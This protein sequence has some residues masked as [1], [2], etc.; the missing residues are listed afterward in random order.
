MH[1]DE[2]CNPSGQLLPSK[3]S[4]NIGNENTSNYKSFSHQQRSLKSPSSILNVKT[5]LSNISNEMCTP[6]GQFRPS[7]SS[8]NVG[9]ENTS[10]YKSFSYQQRSLQS[11]SSIRNVRTPLSN[12]SNGIYNSYNNIQ[13]PISNSRHQSFF[14]NGMQSI[15]SST[16]IQPSSSDNLTRRN[17]RLKR[18]PTNISAIPMFDFTIHGEV[19]DQHTHANIVK[20]VSKDYID[21][22]DQ[23]VVCQICNAKLWTT[24]SIRGKDKQNTSFS[25]CCGYGKVELPDSKEAPP[26]YLNLFRSTDS[27]S[28]Y[29]INNIRRYNS[30]FSFTSMGGKVDAS[31][32]SGKAPFIFRLGGRNYHRIGSLLPLN[33]SKPKFSQL[34]IY[35]TD[36][37]ESNRQTIFGYPSVVRLPFHLP[38]QQQVIYDPDDDIDN[39]LDKPS[40]ASL[41]FTSWLE[42]NKIY[43]QARD[44]TYV[45]FPTKF[46]WK[47]NSRKWEPRE[48]GFL[49]GRIHAVSPKLGETYFLRILLNKVRGPT[50]FEDI[51][52]VNRE[53]CP[54]F[55]DA[56]YAL[57]LLD[58]DKEYIEAIKEASHSATVITYN[59]SLTDHQLKN[60]TLFDIESFLLRNNSTL[61]NFKGMPY[62]DFDCVSSSN[63]RLIAEEL[64]YDITS[65]QNEFQTLIVSLTNEQ[66]GV[67]DDVMAAIEDNKGVIR[68]PEYLLITQSSDPIGSLIEFVYPSLLDNLNDPKI[69]EERSILAP[70]NEVVQEIN[71]RLLSLFP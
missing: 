71:D 25:L 35:D 61:K 7:N 2:M 23:N 44:L 49:I 5:S 47:A 33:G 9:N 1:V 52:T 28:K 14:S 69:F 10:N 27:K 63:N 26:T 58:D 39:I 12:I 46:V 3:N 40:V 54:T 16:I 55:R 65:L 45:E 29:F 57:G 48:I 24:E 13:T 17:Q 66:R 42:C 68:I 62:L 53:I 20:G 60:L 22:G 11:P 43:K 19:N 18:K 64:S 41:M 4:K 8:K 15:N 59:L 38:D 56:C 6:C 21:H 67:F 37:E 70:K 51:R 30:M 36:N 50:S 32:N 31:I 34:Y